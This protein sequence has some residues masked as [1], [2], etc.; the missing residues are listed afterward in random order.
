MVWA[1]GVRGLGLPSFSDL[2]FGA[3]VFWFG[4]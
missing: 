3:R 4:V 1:F 2:G